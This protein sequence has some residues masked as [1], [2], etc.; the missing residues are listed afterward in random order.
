[1]PV[2]YSTTRSAS[3]TYQTGLAPEETLQELARRIQAL[4]SRQMTNSIE[5]LSTHGETRRGLSLGCHDPCN[6][7]ALNSF[8]LFGADSRSGSA[9]RYL[10][11]SA[12]CRPSPQPVRSTTGRDFA[13]SSQPTI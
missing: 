10:I 7:E 2:G 13:Q 12:A 8:F 3:R 9:P 5:V 6:T 11:K 4:D 1:L